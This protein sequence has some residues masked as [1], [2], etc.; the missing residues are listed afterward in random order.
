M[1]RAGVEKEHVSLQRSGRAPTQARATSEVDIERG[2]RR[3]L[4]REPERLAPIVEVAGHPVEMPGGDVPRID[5]VQ[6]Q[7]DDVFVLDRRRVSAGIRD[8]RVPLDLPRARMPEQRVQLGP[9]RR[10]PLFV[11]EQSDLGVEAEVHDLPRDELRQQRLPLVALRMAGDFAGERAVA[12]EE[13]LGEVGH[14]LPELI[15][16]RRRAARVLEILRGERTAQAPRLHVDAKDCLE[17]LR[18]KSSVTLGQAGEG[19][20]NVALHGLRV[21]FGQRGE[22]ALRRLRVREGIP[23]VFA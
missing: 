4:E 22:P 7:G 8:K 3:R 11:S 15:L 21:V 10:D 2:D 16:Y 20:E 23:M 14:R 13:T 17:P 6:D 19:R 1:Q 12:C 18:R 5:E 9:F